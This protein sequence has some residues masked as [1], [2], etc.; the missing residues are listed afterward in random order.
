MEISAREKSILMGLAREAI[1][2]T[3]SGSEP[4]TPPAR[5]ITARLRKESGAFVSIYKNR[6][7]RGS[8]GLV[9]PLV[10][11]WRAVRESAVYAAFRDP[12][13]SPITADE[14][15]DLTL[16]IAVLTS[17]GSAE[18]PSCVHGTVYRKD[19]RQAALLPHCAEVQ[20][21]KAGCTAA[22]RTGTLGLD[23]REWDGVDVKDTFCVEVF[24]EERVR[25]GRRMPGKRR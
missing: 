24:R 15:D 2:L 25:S 16:E 13:F 11:L 18:G 20:E 5:L 23:P 6:M 7:L 9:L 19:F 3:L 10:P 12:R 21:G 14:M 8:M 17:C 4:G 1:H 22:Y